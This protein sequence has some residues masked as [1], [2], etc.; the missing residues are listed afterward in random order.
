[1]I[2][3]G[4]NVNVTLL[5]SQEVYE[6]VAEAYIAGLEKFAASGGDVSR[7]A[8]V[9]SF[10]ISRIDTLVDADRRREAEDCERSRTAGTAQ[11]HTGQSRDRQRKLTYQRYKQIFS[12]RAGRSSQQGRADPARALGQHQH[13][14]SEIP[15]RL[16]VEELIGQDTVNTIPP[17]TFDAFRDHGKLRES[18][19]RRC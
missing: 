11:E 18:S 17:A 3:E 16:Y 19:D 12:G 1:M 13:Q 8:S 10:F 7:V 14:K 9:A 2:S 6:K 15:R 4:I 5:F